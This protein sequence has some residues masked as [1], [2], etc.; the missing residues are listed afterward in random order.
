[1]GRLAGG[2]RC[3]LLRDGMGIDRR[4]PRVLGHARR[5]SRRV[6]REATRHAGR[7]RLDGPPLRP[8]ADLRALPLAAA[9]RARQGRPPRLEPVDLHAPLAR[10]EARYRARMGLRTRIIEWLTKLPPATH[11]L[12]RIERD[13]PVP[14]NDGVVLRADVYHAEAAGAVPTVLMRSPYGRRSFGDLL[15][16][17]H[18]RRG[19]RLVVQS[20]R[21]TFGSGGA[22][23]P[24]FDERADGLATLRWLQRQPWFDGR[25]AMSG[26][27]YLGYVQWAIASEAGGSLTALCPHITM[28]NLAS[29]WY[30]GG[31]FSLDDAIGWSA[32]VSTQESRFAGL[33]RLLGIGARR[34]A[35]HIEELPLLTLDE[36]IVGRRVPF[37]RDFV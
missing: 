28:S 21:G 6:R 5:P 8:D 34:V 1:M 36:R 26:P 17:I 33:S 15:G 29:H 35:R 31:S 2:G 3:H 20:C 23:R 10:R 16:P 7:R 32:M 30:L 13:V 22:F 18:A 25:L 12:G 37:W 4:A 24:Q 14:M 27:S 9:R 19:F 11:R